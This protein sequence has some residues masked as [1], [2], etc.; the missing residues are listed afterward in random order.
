MSIRYLTSGESHGPALIAILDGIPAGLKIDSKIIDADLI[1]RQQGFG[2]GPRMKMESDHAEIIGGIMAGNTLG[3]PIS[4]RIKNKDHENW[5]GKSIDPMTKPRPGHADLTAAIKYNYKDFRQ[6]LERAS[7]RETAAQVAVGAICK[8]Y[9]SQFGIKVQGYVTSIGDVQANLGDIPINR[10]SEIAENNSVRCPDVSAANKMELK[11]KETIKSKDTIGGIIEVAVLGVPAGL[12]SHTHA[13][14]KLSAKLG[15]A[16]LGI[17]AMKGVEIG[18]AFENTRQ[19]GTKVHDAIF[20]ENDKLIRKTNRA[21]GIEGGISNGE[22]IIIRAAMKPIATTL[23]P[24]K[25]VDVVSGI[26]EDT[27][28]ERSDFCPVPRAVP[29]VEAA[30]SIVIANALI[31]KI[32]GDSLSEQLPRYEKLKTSNLSDLEIDGKEHI[33]WP[34]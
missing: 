19:P 20:L 9:L 28:Y 5:V 16:I 24:Q 31:E 8:H 4:L 29:V 2:S 25:T 17:Q 1:R 11:I 6:S 10:R 21:G 22:P 18:A 14:K 26:E 34:D 32:G 12:G 33:W 7:A 23:N 15:A 3:S 27:Q 30:V 13:D